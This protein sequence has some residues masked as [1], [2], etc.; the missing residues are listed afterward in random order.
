[1]SMFSLSRPSRSLFRVIATV[2][3]LATTVAHAAET[4]ALLDEI[5]RKTLLEVT[6]DPA[7]PSLVRSSHYVVSNEDRPHL[8]RPTIDDV[9]GALI[10]VGTDQL[11][12]YASWARP[13][14]IIPM[15]F[16]QVVV[17]VHR[18]YGLF[19]RVA[20]TPDDFIAMWSPKQRAKSSA[21]IEG[22][23]TSPED[24]KALR[25]AFKHGQTPVYARLRRLRRQYRKAKIPSFVNDV[26]VYLYLAKLFRNGRVHALRG[27]L[28]VPD[29]AMA[30]VGRALKKLKVP[31]S[32]VYLSNAEQYFEFTPAYRANFEALDFAP[33]AQLLRTFP[34]GK[35]GDYTYMTQSPSDFQAW[36]DQEK[37][38]KILQIRYHRVRLDARDR[39]VLPAPP[40]PKKAQ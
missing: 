36:L 21:L 26:E 7:P 6:P 22:A 25:K 8:F 11:Y 4:P 13:T 5:Q 18:I 30:S 9:G 19:F 40:E 1:M 27:D 23:A 32:L 15:D 20:D 17:D 33:N 24:L 35:E 10:G 38:K 16:D 34:N 2:A 3:L 12:M 37:T 14:L 39:Y 29:G 28:T 31:V